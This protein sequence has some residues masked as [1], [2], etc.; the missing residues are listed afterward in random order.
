MSVFG[1]TVGGRPGASYAARDQ[2]KKSESAQRYV[3]AALHPRTRAD[4]E[5]HYRAFA[6]WAEMMGV[7][8][9][10]A[11]DRSVI[12]FL[13]DHR[14]WSAVYCRSITLG[15]RLAHTDAVEPRGVVCGPSVATASAST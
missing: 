12:C 8:S 3:R 14:E 9:L 1:F 4:Y 11:S 10:P 6:R 7:S 13:H 5:R 2:A 15:I